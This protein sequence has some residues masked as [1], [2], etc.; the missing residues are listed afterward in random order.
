MQFG[1]DC[2]IFFSFFLLFPYV[3]FLESKNFGSQENFT[4]RLTNDAKSYGKR[5]PVATF[6]QIL[7]KLKRMNEHSA[8]RK[9]IRRKIRK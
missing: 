9:A 7:G 6:A 4:Q 2:A 8:R 3:S 1:R 5:K